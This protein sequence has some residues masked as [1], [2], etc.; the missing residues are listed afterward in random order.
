LGKKVVVIPG[1]GAGPEVTNAAI[2]VLK[3]C[4]TQIELI[5]Y[6]AGSEQWEKNNRKDPTYIPDNTMKALEESDACLKGAT[7]T[8]PIVGTPVSIDLTLRQK[9]ETYSNIRPIKTY[10]RLSPKKDFEFVCF[11]EA[12]EGLI[13]GNEFELS[14]NA[15]VLM[16]KTTKKGCHRIVA[17]A[18]SMAKKNDFKNL[19]V[20]TKRNIFKITDGFLWREVEEISKNY[21]EIIVSELY[22]DNMAQQLVICPEQF[23][24]SVLLST[25]LFMDIISELAAGVIGSVGLSYSANIGD[26]YAFFEAA[27]GS[28]PLFAKQD[29]VNPTAAILSAAWMAEYLGEPHIKVAVFSATEQVINE[30]KNVTFDIGGSATLSQM[31]DAITEIAVNKLRK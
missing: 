17:A 29:K 20:I 12:T 2:T 15:S 9:F 13:G 5:K 30:G 4:N 28:V 1:D 26:S 8:S 10:K 3:A 23:D 22:V 11:R 18:F 25:N 24:Q 14:E 31:R 6:E 21:P 27:H 7:S 19:F 16:R